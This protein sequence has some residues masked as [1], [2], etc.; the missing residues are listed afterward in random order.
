MITKQ[1]HRNSGVIPLAKTAEP[2]VF[3]INRVK[4]MSLPTPAPKP[5]K[6]FNAKARHQARSVLV[7]ALYQWLMAGGNLATISN[8]YIP[9]KD[10]TKKIDVPYFEQLLHGIPTH[11]DTIE[12]AISQAL[13]RPIAQLTPIELT[14]LRIGTYEL[15][16][17]L[18]VPYRVI[19]NEAIELTK[20]FGTE[21][22]HKYVNGVL[23]RISQVIRAGEF[24]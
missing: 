18:D 9:D 11:L 1:N 6:L 16:H 22:G 24:E 23:N 2:S 20:K 13:D 10:N 4:P 3:F 7:Q 15:Q 14:V 12:A 21:T 19:L 5:A 17:C 8:Q